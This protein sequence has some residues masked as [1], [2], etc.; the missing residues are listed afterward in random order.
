MVDK[1]FSDVVTVQL[2]TNKE[3]GKYAKGRCL[4]CSTVHRVSPEDFENESLNRLKLGDNGIER[5]PYIPYGA[6][7][8]DLLK[9]VASM[10]AW[11]CCH[12][13]QEPLDGLPDEM[14]APY[15]IEWGEE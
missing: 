4:S 11:N 10:R 14:E 6:E 8:G 1:L 12:E 7:D 13:G 3:H 9:Y 15:T 2:L 5:E